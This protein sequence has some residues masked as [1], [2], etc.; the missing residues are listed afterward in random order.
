MTTAPLW[1]AAIAGGVAAL[2]LVSLDPAQADARKATATEREAIVAA[3]ERRLGIDE[4]AV[5][6]RTWIIRVAQ[7][8]GRRSSSVGSGSAHWSGSRS[9]IRRTAKCPGACGQ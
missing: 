7:S 2:A 6:K 4:S 5:C 9:A 3:F 8:K 1:K